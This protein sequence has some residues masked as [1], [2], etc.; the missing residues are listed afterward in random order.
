MEI[1][2]Y[3]S[4]LAVGLSLGI[5]GSGGAILTVPILVY[6]FNISPTIAAG[7]SLFVVGITSFSGFF[8]YLNKKLIDIKVAFTFAIPATIVVFI[9]RKFIVP[10][11]PEIIFYIN[12]LIINRDF[13][14]MIFFSLLMFGASLSMIKKKNQLTTLNN[15]S[16]LKLIMLGIFVGFVSGFA[17]AGGGFLIIP[18]L[19]VLAKL[20]MKKAVGTSLLIIAINALIGFTGNIGTFP[21]EWNFLLIFSVITVTGIFI[22]SYLSNKISSEK[23][24]PAFGYFLIFMSVYIFIKEIY[25]L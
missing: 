7:Y 21:I 22:G 23:L 12:G 24:K 9:T 2:G 17:G 4:A 10:S 16:K 5:I 13:V 11:I 15:N 18:S 6:L 25:S 3:I 8:S 19:V 14:I 20:D 1:A